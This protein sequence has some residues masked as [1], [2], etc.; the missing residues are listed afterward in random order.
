MAKPRQIARQQSPGATGAVMEERFG[1]TA[2]I[3][4]PGTDKKERPD[5]HLAFLLRTRA[6]AINIHVTTEEQPLVGGE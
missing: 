4:I 6:S 5:S 2:A 3:I 1:E